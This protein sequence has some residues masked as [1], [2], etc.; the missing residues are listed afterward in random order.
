ML[1]ILEPPSPTS[2]EASRPAGFGSIA[3]AIV[4]ADL[5]GRAAGPAPA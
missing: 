5:P 1:G 2:I 3:V 4:V